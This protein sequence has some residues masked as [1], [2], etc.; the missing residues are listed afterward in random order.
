MGRKIIS[1]LYVMATVLFVV[2]GLLIYQGENSGSMIIS[3]GLLMN[4]V[5]RL[6]NLNKENIRALRMLDILKLCAAVFLAVT[7]VLFFIDFEAL[8]YVIVA[9]IFDIVVNID[10]LLRR[11]P[12][13]D[14]R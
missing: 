7:V 6:V 10:D 5:Y 14:K 8:E 4:V 9:I 3:I 12:V 1:N 11:K 2:G 13:S